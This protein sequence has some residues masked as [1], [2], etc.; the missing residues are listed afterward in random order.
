MNT[1]I[2]GGKGGSVALAIADGYIATCKCVSLTNWHVT[3]AAY[4][5]AS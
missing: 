1:L 5:A 2:R 4:T 3:L